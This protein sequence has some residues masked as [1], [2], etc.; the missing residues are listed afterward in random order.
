MARDGS[1]WYWGLFQDAVHFGLAEA[2]Q[3]A[4]RNGN[5]R[6]DTSSGR[7]DLV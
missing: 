5:G 1:V 6:I 4:D 3:C 7:T 2:G